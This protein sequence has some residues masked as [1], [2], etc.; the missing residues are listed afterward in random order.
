MPEFRPWL[1]RLAAG[2][3]VALSLTAGVA[4]AAPSEAVLAEQAHV[5]LLVNEQRAAAG[6][7]PLVVNETLADGA[8]DYA[9]YMATANFFSH[10]GPDGS[11]VTA[12]AE[13]AGYTTWVFLAENLA[14]GQPTPE[15]VV[16]AWM[17]SPTHRANILAPEATEVGL[18][19]A[20]NPN[21]KFGNY[22]ALE[23]GKRW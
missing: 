20:Y 15:R 17:T 13:A 6:L 2:L 23:F 10:T 5:V 7:A 8:Q 14:A 4:T 19:H 11:D 3:A 9:Q 21:A 1:T 22:W 16:Q 18:G 12:R